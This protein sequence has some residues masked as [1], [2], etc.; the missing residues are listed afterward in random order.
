MMFVLVLKLKSKP[1]SKQ[2]DRRWR[3][4]AR[5]DSR[6]LLAMVAVHPRTRPPWSWSMQMMM[7]LRL[8][9]GS[10]NSLSRERERGERGVLK[11]QPS[12]S[13]HLN[14]LFLHTIFVPPCI[15]PPRTHHLSFIILFHQRHRPFVAFIF[16][17]NTHCSST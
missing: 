17:G 3:E 10:G 5:I 12:I 7:M 15:G 4:I 2:Q 1:A 8:R 14:N 13:R 6:I 16:I 9:S 11:L